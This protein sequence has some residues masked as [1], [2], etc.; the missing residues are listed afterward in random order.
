MPPSMTGE[1]PRVKSSMAAP[2][3]REDSLRQVFKF[4]TDKDVILRNY[5]NFAEGEFRLSISREAAKALDVS[6]EIYDRN[7][8][9]VQISNN[10]IREE[11]FTA[12]GFRYFQYETGGFIYLRY[13]WAKYSFYEEDGRFEIAARLSN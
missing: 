11:Y 12:C 1:V 10:Q 5:V 4:Q 9:W 7:A 3:S 6:D 2:M 8:D 13:R